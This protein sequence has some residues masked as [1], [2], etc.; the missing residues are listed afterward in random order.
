MI[1]IS[2]TVSFHCDKVRKDLNTSKIK[3]LLQNFRRKEL[4][5][6]KANRSG[7]WAETGWLF[8]QLAA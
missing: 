3:V 6:C 1:F 4:R 8:D 7:L 5:K 2:L